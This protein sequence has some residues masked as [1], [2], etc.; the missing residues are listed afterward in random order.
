MA[1]SPLHLAQLPSVAE[2]PGTASALNLGC[3]MCTQ[4]M[5]PRDRGDRC[6][7]AHHP[8]REHLATAQVRTLQSEDP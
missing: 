1:D 6:P 7:W 4:P 3:H 8:L 2:F 5:P